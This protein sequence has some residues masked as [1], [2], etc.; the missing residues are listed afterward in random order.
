MLRSSLTL[1]RFDP[2]KRNST[3][4]EKSVHTTGSWG[5]THELS[6]KQVS[7]KTLTRCLLGNGEERNLQSSSLA[8][9]LAKALQESADFRPH[10]GDE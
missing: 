1:S 5:F 9:I 4:A 10:F 8:L 7:G 3:T 6:K 2:A